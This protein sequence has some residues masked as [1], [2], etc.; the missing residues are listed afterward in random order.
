MSYADFRS[1]SFRKADL[2]GANLAHAKVDAA[3]FTGAD[4]SITSIR[5]TDLSRVLGLTQAQLDKACADSATKVPAG[6]K[7]KTCS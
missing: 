4:L 7:P 2:S 6:L 1:A 3:D 5:G